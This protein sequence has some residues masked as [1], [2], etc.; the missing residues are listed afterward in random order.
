[1]AKV[2]ALLCAGS[3]SRDRR[4]ISDLG[5]PNRA[6]EKG[7][8]GVGAARGDRPDDEHLRACEERLTAV[9]AYSAETEQPFR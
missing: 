6:T 7:C 2:R 8:A 3:A 4:G 9:A 1:M 5:P